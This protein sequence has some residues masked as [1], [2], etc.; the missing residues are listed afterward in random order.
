MRKT[1]SLLGL[2]MVAAFWA[3]ASMGQD[4]DEV[5][6]NADIVML[7]DAGVP[8]KAIVNKINSTPTDFD[9]SVEQLVALS[10][11]GVDAS[12]LAAMTNQD[13]NANSKP[14]AAPEPE[15]DPQQAAKPDP[16]EPV[17]EQTA[18]APPAVSRQPLASGEQTAT[19]RMVNTGNTFS[20]AL[21][22][23]GFGP[24]MVVVPAGRFRMGCAKRRDCFPD[25]RPVHRVT[26]AR[27]LAV[28]K[29]AVTFDD[30]DRFA[31]ARKPLDEGWGRG[32]RPVINVSWEN[33]TAYA[34]WLAAETGEHYR[35]LT[36]A[37]WEYA[38]R[39]GSAK[40]FH[41]G[42]DA[43]Q[44]CRYG[45]H[46]DAST[47]YE[48][49]NTDCSD[50]VGKRTSVVGRYAPNA[51]GL[52][53][54]HGNVWEW[55]QDC[56]NDHYRRAPKDGSSWLEGDCSK[57]VLRGGAWGYEPE[58]LRSAFRTSLNARQRSSDIGFRV[59]RVLSP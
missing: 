29:Y 48:W 19:A 56:W 21:R 55:V 16:V 58:S 44:L 23:G 20:D 40:K 34:A 32:R 15:T 52:Y 5:L 24:E 36:E 51:F 14:E 2:L 3:P 28:S 54:I 1:I 38:A 10:K 12:V 27:D 7:T 57:R 11:A 53:D 50:G 18:A 22:S 59:A 6:T 26:I 46:A 39:S 4:Q 41:F 8:A 35:L 43:S 42:D 47:D 33:A 49:S 17:Y 25:E 45:N 30:Y 9:T 13:S 37:E 31:G